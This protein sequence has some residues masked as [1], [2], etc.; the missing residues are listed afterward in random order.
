MSHTSLL[1]VLALV[2]TVAVSTLGTASVAI[3][4]PAGESSERAS[5]I[6]TLRPGTD[7]DGVARESRGRG[8]DVALVYRHAVAGFA[9]RMGQRL[10]DELRRDGRV[11]SVERDVVVRASALQTSATWGLDRVDQRALPLDGSYSYDHTGSGVTVYVLDTGVR[12]SHAELAGRVASGY[13][14][15]NDGNGTSDCNG[16][17]THVAGSVAGSTYGA[18]KQATIVPVRV[19]GCDG[20]GSMSG[21]IAGVDWVTAHHPAGAP[22]VANMSLGGPAYSALDTA[23]KNSIVDGTT[24]TVSAGNDNVD[25]CTQ[26]PARLGEV[27]TVAATT[28]SDS[29][30]SYSNWGACVDVF[31]PGSGIR[32]AYNGSDAAT[33]TM[34]GTSMA[35][36]HVAGVAA[37]YLNGSPSATPATVSAAIVNGATANVVSS[38]AGSPNRLA[39]SRLVAS[40]TSPTGTAPAAPA[41]PRASSARRAI[42]VTWIAP[43]DG[44]S[45]VSGYRV[46]VHPRL[47]RRRHVVR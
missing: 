35:S 31:A 40:T 38:A 1:R 23:V 28:S 41:A 17:G 15:I 47:R 20:S 45:P 27:L 11:E 18:A 4:A 14:A 24:Y 43:A 34:S 36:P 12:A 3:A 32:S 5:F 2:G 21:V 16:H 46:P 33:A 13:T 10:A 6:V 26:S 9:G 8:A 30:A 39:Y 42:D 29:R 7:P 37:L 25:A 22:A 44:G 19:L